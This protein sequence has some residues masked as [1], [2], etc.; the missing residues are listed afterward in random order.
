MKPRINTLSEVAFSCCVY[1]SIE[2]FNKTFNDFIDATK[3]S[4][5]LSDSNHRNAL[6]KWLNQWGC[7]YKK[8]DHEMLSESIATW[9][10]YNGSNLPQ[11]NVNLWELNKDDLIKIGQAYED[12]AGRYASYQISGEKKVLKRIGPTGAS[13]ILFAIRP[14]CLI[15]W[16]DPIRA[17]FGFN[18]IYYASSSYIDYLQ[19]S[20]SL[21]SKLC[22][23]YNFNLLDLPK[24]LDRPQSTVPMIID[25]YYWITVTRKCN[26]PDHKLFSKWA[27]WSRATSDDELINTKNIP[28]IEKPIIKSTTKWNEHLKL[29]DVISNEIEE[30]T[31]GNINVTFTPAEVID[32]LRNKYSDINKDSIRC[33]IIQDCVNHTSRKH[34]LSSQRDLYYRLEKGVFRLYD[35]DRD[36]KWD[37]QGQRVE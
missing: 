25:H 28:V 33:Q 29:K 2:N 30:I 31:G 18:E 13:K 1:D 35:R 9:I 12:L 3:P 16:D 34:Y 17:Q 19:Y 5:N 20:C 7:R 37:W 10:L 6:I 26:I 4:I 22:S 36:G 11:V 32:K 24:Q 14:N 8:E 21:F 27:Y 15:P 23:R